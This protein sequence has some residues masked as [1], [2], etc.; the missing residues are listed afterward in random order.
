[1]TVTVTVG[2]GT[3]AK[4]HKGLVSRLRLHLTWA[5]VWR[6]LLQ[7]KFS[8]AWRPQRHHGLFGTGSPGR[9]PRLSHSP[10]VPVQCCFTSTETIRLIRDGLL[11]TATSTFTQLMSSSSMLLYAHRNQRLIMDGLPR[12]ATSTFTD[13]APGELC[14]CGYNMTAL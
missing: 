2:M 3:H 13:T 10:G 9:P 1:M 7:V 14:S 8:V 12:T 5:S 11:R 4:S 6:R